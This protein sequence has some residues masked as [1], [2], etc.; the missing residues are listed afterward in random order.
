[1]VN[2]QYDVKVKGWISDAGGEYRS[3][4]FN[5]LLANNGITTYQSAPHVLQ[6]NGCT[7]CFV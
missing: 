2:T 4:A 7:E 5:K 6:Q 1:M 3:E